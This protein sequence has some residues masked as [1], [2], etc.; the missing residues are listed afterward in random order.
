[1]ALIPKE[2]F[3][4]KLTYTVLHPKDKELQKVKATP[5]LAVAVPQTKAIYN[6]KLCLKCKSQRYI[7]FYIIIF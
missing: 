3:K 6:A 5:H 4:R 7:L 2:L 1:M